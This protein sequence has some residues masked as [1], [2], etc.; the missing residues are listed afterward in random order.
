MFCL[1]EEK[2]LT[3]YEP[4]KLFGPDTFL[5]GI[6]ETHPVGVC[7]L[8]D[9][10]QQVVACADPLCFPPQCS[11]VVRNILYPGVTATVS[12]M[13]RYFKDLGL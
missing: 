9:T 8:P 12:P 4:I 1:G 6:I 5:Y 10:F 3:D 2:H 13:E 7:H 11:K